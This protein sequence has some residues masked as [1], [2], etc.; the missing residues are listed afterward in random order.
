MKTIFKKYNKIIDSYIE[1]NEM[2]IDVLFV[3]ST[4]VKLENYNNCY[5]VNKVVVDCTKEN[6]IQIVYL[7]D[8]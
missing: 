1:I 4:Y 3:E 7:K 5:I 8:I 6:P 2:N